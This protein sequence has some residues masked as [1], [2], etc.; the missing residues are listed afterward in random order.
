MINLLDVSIFGP[1]RFGGILQIITVFFSYFQ[2]LRG[3]LTLWG[4][5]SNTTGQPLTLI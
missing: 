3:A 5:L 2:A 4:L 1:R